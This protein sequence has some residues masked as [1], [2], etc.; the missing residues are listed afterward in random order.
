MKY[1]KTYEAYGSILL[2]LSNNI[3]KE[4]IDK[5]KSLLNIG[6]SILE[7]SCGN[8]SDAIE[9]NKY[10]NII[11]TD[12]DE[13]YVEYVNSKGIECINHDTRV[14]FPFNDK[15]FD[16]IYSRLGL[17]YFEIDELKKIF[18]ELNRICDGYILFTVKL[19]NDIQ[20]GKV[21]LTK[22]VWEDLVS[23]EFTILESNVRNGI[24]YNNESVWLEILASN[25]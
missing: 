18:N 15:K 9:L 8:G 13:N 17:H 14:K 16:L 12:T 4:L 25:K 2:N 23:N 20:T 1:I 3:D 19:V 6:D 5:I 11:T 21:I 22:E 24:L 10:Y 7:I